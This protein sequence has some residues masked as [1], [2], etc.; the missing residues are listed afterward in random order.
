MDDLSTSF[1]ETN[2][3]REELEENIN[4]LNNDVEVLSDQGEKLKSIFSNVDEK[5]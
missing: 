2:N 4:N 5:D 3:I 1:D